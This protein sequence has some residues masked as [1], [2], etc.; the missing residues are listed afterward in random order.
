MDIWT[1]L[2]R[3][4]FWTTERL[5][6]RPFAFSDRDDFWAICSNPQNLNFI[7]PAQASRYESDYLLVHYFMKAP[8]GIWAIEDKETGKMI[9]AIRFEKLNS[10]SQ[11]T[12]IGYFLHRDFWNQGY[13]TECLQTLV[14]LSFTAMDLKAL[15]VIIHQENAASH[16]VAQKS[17]FRLT[18]EFKGSDRYSH[19]MRSYAEYQILKG[20][21]HYE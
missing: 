13:M 21:Y 8:L 1:E 19:K 15:K 10:L 7:F 16:R 2:G 4:A 9:G 14:Y 12:E 18:R 20:D 17:G 11:I 6:M 5:I 3:Y